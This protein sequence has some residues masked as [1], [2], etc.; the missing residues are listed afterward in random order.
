VLPTPFDDDGRVDEDSLRTLVRC[1]RSWGVDGVTALGVMG[2]AAALSDAERQRVLSAVID[3]ADGTPVAVGCSAAALHRVSCLIDDAASAGASAVMVAAPQ[4]SRNIDAVVSL[5]AALPQVL[6]VIV[7][8]E[9]AATGTL[10]PVSALVAS[11]E[12]CGAAA[13]KLEDPPTPP[14]IARLRQ[15]LPD[16]PIF[17]GLGG[18]YALGELRRGAAG[19][20]TGFSFPEVLAAVRRHVESG[21]L[22]AA[23]RVFERFLPLI[24]LEAQTG[25]GLA[26]RKQIL[27]RRGALQTATTRL[28]PR[29][30]DVHAD[31]IDEALHSCGVSDP[32]Q[33]WE[34]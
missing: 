24:H 23:R 17:G 12:G 27:V 5:F 6:P 18:G 10:L 19:T 20:M 33:R 25:V 2:E 11:A 7:Q 30:D 22:A 21:D 34:P 16:V 26:I 29:L 4:N 8:D 1:V 31:E 3:A 14:K 28:V 13:I 15:H 9:P 32:T